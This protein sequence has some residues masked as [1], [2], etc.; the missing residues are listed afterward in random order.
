MVTCGL[1]RHKISQVMD[2]QEQTAVTFNSIYKRSLWKMYSN[3]CNCGQFCASILINR[4]R[5]TYTC[6]NALDP[7][8]FG[9]WFVAYHV[10]RHYKNHCW[11]IINRT[12]ANKLNWKLNWMQHYAHERMHLTMS[13]VM[14]RPLCFDLKGFYKSG[15]HLFLPLFSRLHQITGRP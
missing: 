1:W 9:K 15:L 12:L 8:R 3:V 7:H 13:S 10:S 4:G 6:V 5:E 14:W 2:P 11:H